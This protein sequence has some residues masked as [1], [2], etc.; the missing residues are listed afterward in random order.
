MGGTH[1]IEKVGRLG[2]VLWPWAVV[3]LTAPGC[4]LLLDPDCAST[5]DCAVGVCSD[6]VCVTSSAGGSGGNAG[7]GG[8]GG[9]E[10][11]MSIDAEAMGGMGGMGGDVGGMGG[12]MPDMGADAEPDM[13]PDAEPDMMVDMMVVEPQRPVCNILSPGPGTLVS[14]AEAEIRIQVTDADTAP[15][16]LAVTLDDMPVT[17]DDEGVATVMLPLDEG[18]RTVTLSGSDGELSC[19]DTLDLVVDRTGPELIIRVPEGGSAPTRSRNFEVVFD[20]IDP[21][22]G[23]VGI[24][25]I[26]G[27]LN[28]D[29]L[30]INAVAP[31]DQPNEYTVRLSLNAGENT[32]Q[33]TAV[34]RAGN[35]TEPPVSVT[36]T[37]DLEDPVLQIDSPVRDVVLAEETAQL[38]GSVSDNLG[39]Q[40]VQVGL[41]IVDVNTQQRAEQVIVPD[42]EGRFSQEIML[43]EG[44][45]D[46]IL[47]ATDSAG[48]EARENRRVRVDTS[49]PTLTILEPDNG[50]VL[51]NNQ[52]TVV[53]EARPFVTGV[54]VQVEDLAEVEAIYDAE[55]DRYTAVVNLPGA[56]NH[57]ITAVATNQANRQTTERINVLFDD[58]PPN[59]VIDRPRQDDCIAADP[60]EVCGRATD[61]ESGV[62]TLR[63]NNAP[64]QLGFDGS[65]CADIALQEGSNLPI[66]VNADNFGFLRGEDVITVNV[67]RTE[68]NLFIDSPLPDTFVNGA[69]GVIT[70]SGRTFD[71]NCAGLGNDALTFNGEIVPLQDDG[72][73]NLTR[74]EVDIEAVEGPNAVTL[75]STDTLGNEARETVNFIVDS[76][77]PV[78]A[79]RAPLEDARIVREAQVF[80]EA[81]VL[82]TGSGLASVTLN[83]L[84][85]PE[86]SFN[87]DTGETLVRGSV[88]LNRGALNQ[89]QVVAVDTVGLRHEINFEVLQDEIAP[90]VTI[91]HPVPLQNVDALVDLAGTVT[92]GFS[93]S[94]VVEVRVN[95][96]ESGQSV[97]ADYDA[98]AGTWT[99]EDLVL[100]PD[101][102]GEASLEVLATDL[103][104]NISAVQSLNVRV[105]QFA[106]IDPVFNGL[107]V[108]SGVGWVGVADL[109]GDGRPDIVALPQDVGGIPA[110][111]LLGATGRYTALTAEQAGLPDGVVSGA[112]LGDI[113]SDGLIDLVIASPDGDNALLLGIGGGAFAEV[114]NIGFTNSPAT[115]VAFADLNRDRRL[116]VVFVAGADSAIYQQ[117]VDGTFFSTPLGDAGIVGLTD[118]TSIEI[119]DF[120][121]DGILDIVG[122]GTGTSLWRGQ[123]NVI[124]A[125][126][127]PDSTGFADRDGTHMNIF[128][129]DRDGDL[130]GLL[131]EDSQFQLYASDNLGTEWVSSLFGVERPGGARASTFGDIDGDTRDDFIVYGDAGA[132]LYYQRVG[133]GGAIEYE[134]ADNPSL[135]LVPFGA[136]RAL[137]MVDVDADGD[138]DLVVGTA[139]GVNVIR[140]NL[141][142]LDVEYNYAQLIVRRGLA[143]EDGPEDAIGVVITQDLPGGEVI[144]RALRASSTVP[145]VLTLGESTIA[146]IAVR[147][148]DIFEVGNNVRNTP[149][150]DGEQ[151]LIN[152]SDQ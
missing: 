84:P 23:L 2:R 52:V 28:G 1:M 61:D 92:D 130:D 113:N 82:E 123:D 74:Y 5:N 145:T 64:A 143:N 117:L 67:D 22:A 79:L 62:L 150:Q 60:V 70:I 86:S 17:L 77:P 91:A 54:T 57:T 6:G 118:A 49:P 106:P 89:V 4:S 46:L 152:N 105:R 90:T 112:D 121:R 72:T 13:M 11:D 141:T 149:V 56:G 42:E 108:A 19:E 80:V 139:A 33:L 78:I 41:A 129:V 148:V 95:E 44:D 76:T 125:E 97:I 94:G 69:V 135:G 151:R 83:G 55:L 68:P 102:A 3:L 31:G 128:D 111:Y 75:V 134:Q 142:D 35:Q 109:N 45:N 27:T 43:F 37:L 132:Q 26:Q 16:A 138:L 93:G 140:S 100:A 40:G 20:A 10:P 126:L 58:T 14:T 88:S 24:G 32:L 65:F 87:P 12:E 107:D 36:L 15:E 114:P 47:I 98:E 30:R 131:L 146:D 34:D 50:E 96:I 119:V 38:T 63:V 18:A 124:F 51:Q 99:Y 104:G 136:V 25:S 133:E 147:F 116:D 9:G 120:N 81:V 122:T 73:G 127:D 137:E 115:D 53:C 103:A 7:N 85:F 48:N 59:I 144:D 29:P 8:A 71:V 110:V 39:A 21:L 101:G 66:R